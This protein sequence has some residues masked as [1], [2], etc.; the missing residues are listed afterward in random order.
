MSLQIRLDRLTLSPATNIHSRPLSKTTLHRVGAT[1]TIRS[2]T[3]NSGREQHGAEPT[4]SD[5]KYRAN[6]RGLTEA[7]LS[8]YDKSQSVEAPDWETSTAS[9]RT[10]CAEGQRT[11]SHG[12]SSE[13]ETDAHKRLG[14][15]DHQAMSFNVERQSSEALL[16]ALRTVTGYPE[17]TSGS[18]DSALCTQSHTEPIQHQ[19]QHGKQ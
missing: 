11:P 18:R 2:C 12:S 8:L 4:P 15:V 16:Q 3:R 9:S 10:L 7:T 19:G 6:S 13:E 17:T 5:H 1:D 14:S